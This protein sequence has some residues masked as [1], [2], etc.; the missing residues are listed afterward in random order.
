MNEF[1]IELSYNNHTDYFVLPVNPA[2]IQVK[3][4]VKGKTYDL[5]GAGQ[6]S[7]EINVI[8][9]RQLTEISFE[10]IF[11]AQWYPFVIVKSDELLKPLAY[12][13]FIKR[14]LGA[15]HPIRFIAVGSSFV[16]NLPMSIEK[17]D[18]KE[19][20]GSPGDIE[21]SLS[22]KEYVFYSAKEIK[23]VKQGDGE[24]TLVEQQ[25]DRLNDRITPDTYTFVE[26]DNLTKIAREILGDDSRAKEIQ[27][28]NGIKDSELRQIPIGKVIKIP[29]AYK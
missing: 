15:K 24:D 27:L 26:G 12:I 9:S 3:E 29:Q 5:V 28:L 21:Y 8:K 7:G 19:A 11:P 18:W 2:S 22:L 1:A 25:P 14:W 20:A 13:N 17:F 10:G 23:V 6:G 16:I 4:G